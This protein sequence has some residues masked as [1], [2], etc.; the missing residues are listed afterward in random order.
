MLLCR[1]LLKVL[2]HSRALLHRTKIIQKKAFLIVCLGVLLQATVAHYR[3]SSFVMHALRGDDGASDSENAGM[4]E[5]SPTP[6]AAQALR[7]IGPIG[8]APPGPTPA[9]LPAPSAPAPAPA[10][11][12][13]PAQP[14]AAAD[15][16]PNQPDSGTYIYITRKM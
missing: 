2:H 15:H 6:Q 10:D 13:P 7:P 11:A 1:L 3:S 16:G 5:V 14:D 9:R 12:A 8:T 4:A